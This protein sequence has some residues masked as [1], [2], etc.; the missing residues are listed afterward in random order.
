MTAGDICSGK[1]RQKKIEPCRNGKLI[2]V[3]YSGNY[4][5][6]LKKQAID[7]FPVEN[8]INYPKVVLLKPCLFRFFA[9]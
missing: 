6:C 8:H 7:V 5:I 2:T 4:T 3:I 1:N 9:A